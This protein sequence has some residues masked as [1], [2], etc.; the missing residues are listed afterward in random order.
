MYYVG[1]IRLLVEARLVT[2]DEVNCPPRLRPDPMPAPPA[3]SN[4][5]T[6]PMPV[7]VLDLYRARQLRAC[8]SRRESGVRPHD[9]CPV[10]NDRVQYCPSTGRPMSPYAGRWA[11]HIDQIDTQLLRGP[12]MNGVRY[13]SVCSKSSGMVRR[14]DRFES[15]DPAEAHDAGAG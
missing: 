11:A 2:D 12:C 5:A 14:G 10:D 6:A 9:F 8:G 15:W 1:H 13:F 4:V 7:L 3:D